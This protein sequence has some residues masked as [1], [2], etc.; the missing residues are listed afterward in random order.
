MGNPDL[1]YATVIGAEARARESN[2][3]VFGRTNGYD[4][5]YIY[6]RLRAQVGGVGATHVCLDN[7][8]DYHDYF[9]VCT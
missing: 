3:M 1:I 8:V 2:M 5:V 4:R 9:A 6:G 7:S